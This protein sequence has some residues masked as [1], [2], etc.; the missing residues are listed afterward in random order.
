[1][2]T[3]RDEWHEMIRVNIRK[4]A[5]SRRLRRP[6]QEAVHQAVVDVTRVPIREIMETQYHDGP[7]RRARWLLIWGLYEILQMSYEGIN[8]YLGM[9]QTTIRRA[10]RL[11]TTKFPQECQEIWKRCNP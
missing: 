4:S 7:R 2:M 1:M 10:R 11:A 9:D 5:K 8:N 3:A 6:L